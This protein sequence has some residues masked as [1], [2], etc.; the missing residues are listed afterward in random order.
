M[1]NY[2]RTFFSKCDSF[3]TR[4]RFYKTLM[5]IRNLLEIT[6]LLIRVE[7]RLFIFYKGQT[8]NVDIVKLRTLNRDE[9]MKNFSVLNEI[10]FKALMLNN[11]IVDPFLKVDLLFVKGKRK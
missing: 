8:F 2:Y 9:T 1:V 4:A 10:L 3:S 5:G 11:A 6:Q 7:L